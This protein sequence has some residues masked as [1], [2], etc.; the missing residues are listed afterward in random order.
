[1]K[2]S[3]LASLVRL[4]SRV[5]NRINTANVAPPAVPHMFTMNCERSAA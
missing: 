2:K 1:M 3:S 5:T 4:K